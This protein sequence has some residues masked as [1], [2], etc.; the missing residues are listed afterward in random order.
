MPPTESGWLREMMRSDLEQVLAWRNHPSVR[1]HMYTNEPINLT[2]HTRWY[3]RAAAEPGRHLLIFEREEGAAGFVNLHQI[4]AGGIF[5]WGFYA[6]PEAPKG[7]GHALGRAAL[8]FAFAEAGAH[9]VCGEVIASN[10]ASLRFHLRHGFT[11]EGILRDQY[12]DGDRYHD[13][14]CFGLLQREWQAQ[15]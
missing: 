4:G 6:A 8:R 3:E 10:E 13:V 14:N 1:Q 11:Q 5:D 2:D 12:F 9:K 7:T 15:T